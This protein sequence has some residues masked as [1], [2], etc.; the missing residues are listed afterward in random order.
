MIGA[1]RERS[2]LGD[3]P[4]ERELASGGGS[5]QEAAGRALLPARVLRPIRAKVY[6]PR[7]TTV[8]RLRGSR[9]R[10]SGTEAACI[11]P[12]ERMGRT[13]TTDPAALRLRASRLAERVTSAD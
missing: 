6:G 3:L 2:I 8:S 11:E 4:V 10:P 7:S 13:S 9:T 12:G 1:G 5:A